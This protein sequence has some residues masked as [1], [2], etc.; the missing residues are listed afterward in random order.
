MDLEGWIKSFHLPISS[1]HWKTLPSSPDPCLLGCRQVNILFRPS[2]QVPRQLVRWRCLLFLSLLGKEIG[3]SLYQG[4]L[5]ISDYLTIRLLACRFAFFL[6]KLLSTNRLKYILIPLTCPLKKQRI[7]ILGREKEGFC[8]RSRRG[9]GGQRKVQPQF[10]SENAIVFCA[11]VRLGVNDSVR[12]SSPTKGLL[13]L[14]VLY[15]P[16][17]SVLGYPQYTRGSSL[18]QNKVPVQNESDK[19]QAQTRS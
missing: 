6:L 9:G 14:F 19:A 12:S 10:G 5:Y 16:L 15:T 18:E 7:L 3:I 8:A 2:G 11:H 4:C 1:L 17:A 13:R